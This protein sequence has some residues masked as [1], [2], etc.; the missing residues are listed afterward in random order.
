VTVDRPPP[1]SL[2]VELSTDVDLGRLRQVLVA[3]FGWE[4]GMEA[5][6]DAVLYGWEHRD[7]LAEMANPV[8]YL[9]RV[10][11]TSVRRQSRWRRTIDLPVPPPDR[12]PEVEP[13]LVRCLAGLTERQR[14]VV[15]LVHA[16]GWSHE[17]VAEVLDLGVSSVRNHLRRGLEHLRRG[18]GVQ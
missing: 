12:M 9:Y 10:A 2:V 15:L 1:L 7:R 6:Q 3:R 16:H 18:L 4:T 13:K 17:E 11:Q 14:V 5:W 8:G